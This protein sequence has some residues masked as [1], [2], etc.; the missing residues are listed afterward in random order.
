MT[1]KQKLS[2]CIKLQNRP[3]TIGLPIITNVAVASFPFA[4]SARNI[5][6]IVAD[7]MTPDKEAAY[8]PTHISQISESIQHCCM[9][10][11]KKLQRKATSLLLFILCTVCP[12]VPPF[13]TSCLCSALI[14]L[15]R[16]VLLI[17][18]NFYSTTSQSG[19]FAF[20]LSTLHSCPQNNKIRSLAC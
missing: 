7:D 18:L 1:W 16:L 5:G 13:S 15:K 3:P 8:T 12:F 11:A 20:C 19:V 17:S 6:F 10:G 2:F 4:S 9:P 14:S